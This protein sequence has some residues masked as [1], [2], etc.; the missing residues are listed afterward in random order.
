MMPQREARR[1]AQFHGFRSLPPE[2]RIMIYKLLLVKDRFIV[3]DERPGSLSP[4][5]NNRI[6]AGLLLG[7]SKDIQDEAEACFFKNNEFLLPAELW[8][9]P[10]VFSLRRTVT[11]RQKQQF[12]EFRRMSINITRDSMPTDIPPNKNTSSGHAEMDQYIPQLM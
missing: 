4:R 2:L 12:S 7:V 8:R 3:M 6:T 10:D 9:A 1:G 5:F 11:T